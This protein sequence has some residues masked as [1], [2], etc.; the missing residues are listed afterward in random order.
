MEN[1]GITTIIPKV[2]NIL[3][4]V[5]KFL[6]NAARNSFLKDFTVD[7]LIEAGHTMDLPPQSCKFVPADQAAVAKQILT[8][9]NLDESLREFAL[10]V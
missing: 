7:A 8:R 5:C 4:H 1:G 3:K 6:T 10:G 2:P 9:F